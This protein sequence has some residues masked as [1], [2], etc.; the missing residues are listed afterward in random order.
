MR[1]SKVIAILAGACSV[2]A[3]SSATVPFPAGYRKWAVTKSF[4]ASPKSK[5][6]GFHHYYANGK[7]TEGFTT[8]KFPDGSVIVMNVSKWSNMEAAASKAS[9]SV[10]Q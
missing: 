5:T 3:D 2:F 1:I 4:I 7:A 8:G 9:G 6:A 10:L